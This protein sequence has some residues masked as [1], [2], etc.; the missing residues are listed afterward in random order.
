MIDQRLKQDLIKQKRLVKS[1]Y[2]AGI[3]VP[4]DY[5]YFINKIERQLR[6]IAEREKCQDAQ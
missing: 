6:E 2:E 3:I 4:A 1:D 5:D